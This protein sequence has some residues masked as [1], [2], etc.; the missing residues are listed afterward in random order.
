VLFCARLPSKCCYCMNQ[1]ICVSKNSEFCADFE[2]LEKF[3][4][5]KF[6]IKNVTEICFFN[7]LFVQ[8][9]FAY[10]FVL[11]FLKNFLRIWKQREIL[12]FLIPFMNLK[13]D[14][15]HFL[16]TLI[17]GLRCI[18]VRHLYRRTCYLIS[19]SGTTILRDIVPGTVG[20]QLRVLNP[21]PHP[22]KSPALRHSCLS[23]RSLLPSWI[24]IRIWIHGP[25]DPEHTVRR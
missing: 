22:E 10:N 16:E 25:L 18:P 1:K 4:T 7:Y 14:I 12:C 23:K 24:R 3:H 19:I 11:V 6:I 5:K 17:R 15:E 2:F 8:T 20:F 13:K 21:N 9:C